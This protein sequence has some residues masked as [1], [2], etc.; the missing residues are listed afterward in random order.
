MK[1]GNSI[2]I[3]T[4]LG[5]FLLDKRKTSIDGV[6]MPTLETLEQR[7]SQ[8]EGSTETIAI[9]EEPTIVQEEVQEQLEKGTVGVA[10][11]PCTASHIATCAGELNESIRFA[12]KD[13]LDPEVVIRIDHCLSEIGAAERIDLAP[14]AVVG[15]PEEER[16]VARYAANELREIRHGLEWFK[17]ADELEELAAKTSTLQHTIGREWLRIRLN[18]GGEL[19]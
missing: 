18:K 13:L 9:Q 17:T 11:L 4:Q 16:K 3:A 2:Q 15:L 1:I 5:S 10:C 12:R 7:L 14:E 19:T 6:E 8:I